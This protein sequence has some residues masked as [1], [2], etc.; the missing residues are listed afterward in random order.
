[1]HTHKWTQVQFLTFKENEWILRNSK[2]NTHYAN[3]LIALEDIS[4][5]HPEQRILE[6]KLMPAIISMWCVPEIVANI[7]QKWVKKP[8]INNITTLHQIYCSYCDLSSESFSAFW[9]ND[10]KILTQHSYRT[11]TASELSEYGETPRYFITWITIV[12][13][14]CQQKSSKSVFTK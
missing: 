11:S 8:N 5:Q 9:L 10:L 2:E 1:M 13:T 7:F 3:M 4:T 6:L 12:K 14:I